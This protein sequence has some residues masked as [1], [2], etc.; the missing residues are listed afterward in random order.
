MRVYKNSKFEQTENLGSVIKSSYR[1]PVYKSVVSTYETRRS[2]KRGLK[3]PDWMEGDLAKQF[4][5]FSFSSFTFVFSFWGGGG[6]RWEKPDMGMYYY[7]VKFLIFA[8][9]YVFSLNR[10]Y[11]FSEHM[12]LY[13]CCLTIYRWNE[14]ITFK[15]SNKKWIFAKPRLQISEHTN[16][17][18]CCPTLD[19]WN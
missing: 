2:L 18:I 1:F 13:I 5:Q 14:V 6:V 17:Y 19:R 15:F 11:N 10:E 4:K 12:N 16:M 7:F 3:I 8:I 9:K